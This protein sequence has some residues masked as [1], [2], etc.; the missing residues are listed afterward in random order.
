MASPRALMTVPTLFSPDLNVQSIR[1]CAAYFS[2]SQCAG[3]S[4]FGGYGNGNASDGDSWK[5]P[6]AMETPA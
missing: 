3:R 4:S 1:G 2:T 6:R 5:V